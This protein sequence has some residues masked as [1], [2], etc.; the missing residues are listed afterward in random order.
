[1]FTLAA[2]GPQAAGSPSLLYSVNCYDGV[3]QWQNIS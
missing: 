3:S 2:F 1:M